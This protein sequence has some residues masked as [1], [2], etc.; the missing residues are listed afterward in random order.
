[1]HDDSSVRK[2]LERVI[3]S[4]KASHDS[5]L[6]SISEL[7]RLARVSRSNVYAHHRDIVEMLRPMRDVGSIN[8]KKDIDAQCNVDDV[9][10]LK[11]RIAALQLICVELYDE[12]R[13]ARS[14]GSKTSK[15]IL[16]KMS[17]E[18]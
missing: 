16:K 3:S 8:K 17:P 1:M 10:Q 12:L 15:P 11:K 14:M 2:R 6:I 18:C 7:C 13:I 9:E 5:H 4:L